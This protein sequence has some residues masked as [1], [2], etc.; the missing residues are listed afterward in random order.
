M[1]NT[2]L[3]K[4]SSLA[5][6]KCIDIKKSET[7]AFS[8]LT[9]KTRLLFMIWRK[10]DTFIEAKEWDNFVSLNISP[11]YPFNDA[12]VFLIKVGL[13]FKDEAQHRFDFTAS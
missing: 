11:T 4:L 6:K 10:N 8:F 13:T 7:T 12:N 1:P 5:A 2:S 9:R 3:I